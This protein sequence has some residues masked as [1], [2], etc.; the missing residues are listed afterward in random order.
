MFAS[1]V[2]LTTT[3]AANNATTTTT[4]VAELRDI[5]LCQLAM[6]KSV[7]NDAASKFQTADENADMDTVS[8]ESSAAVM[9]TYCTLMC[10]AHLLVFTFVLAFGG[11]GGDALTFRVSHR[12]RCPGRSSLAC[13]IGG[14]VSSSC[15]LLL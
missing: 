13:S 7:P 9:V 14:G 15:Q 1:N 12:L 5:E 3:T 11:G 4:V 6:D 8:Y 2:E 10:C